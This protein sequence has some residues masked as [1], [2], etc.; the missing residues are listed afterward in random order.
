MPSPPSDYENDIMKFLQTAIEEGDAFLQT[1]EGYD[2][3]PQVI[4]A[5]FNKSTTFG[6]S[7][8][9]S[10]TVNHFAR[11]A[12]DLAAGMTDVRPFWEYRTANHAFDRQISI[13]GRLSEH[14]WLQRQADMRFVDAM[15]YVFAAGTAFPHLTWNPDLQ[16]LEL[17]VEDPRDVIPIRPTSTM[18]LQD[19]M[20]VTIRRE[21]TVNYLRDKYRNAD[22]SKIVAEKDASMTKALANTRYG[23]LLEKLGSPFHN[24]MQQEATHLQVPKIPTCTCYTTYLKDHTLNKGSGPRYMGEWHLGPTKKQGVIRRIFGGETIDEREECPKCARGEY[25]HPLTNWSYAVEPGDPLYP[26]GRMIISTKHGVLHDGPSIYWHGSVIPFPLVKLTLDPFPWSWFGKAAGWDLLP[27]QNSLNKAVQVW[28]DWLAQLAQ[29]AVIADKNS[30]SRAELNKINSRQAGLK[31]R[32]NPLAGKGVQIVPPP[33][34]PNDYWQ[35][36]KF[37]IDSM[38]ELSGVVNVQSLMRLNQ[39]PSSDTIEQVMAAMS[40]SVRLRSRSLEATIREFATLLAYDFTQFYTL[41]MRLTI[42]G[43]Q[44]VTKEDFDFDPG[45]LVPDYVHREDFGPDG[46]PHVKAQLRG[47]RP[48]YVRA[49]EVLRQ[50]EFHVAPGSLLES[51]GITEKMMYLQLFRMGAMDLWTMWDKLGIP[52]IG[53]PPATTIPERLAAQKDMGLEPQV[54]AV[55]RKATGQQTPKMKS[56][57]AIS[58]SG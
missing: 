18:A 49:K 24:W 40:P 13:Y 47:P 3:I 55:G 57:G 11:I 20:G 58:E 33:N 51:S 10:T 41:P 12:L 7:K 14:W 27:L 30:V 4:D 48:R 46:Q 38:N 21:H 17:L 29:P 15:K 8:L 19:C 50:L 2:K 45:T 31:I 28:D 26:N 44:G 37:L 43:S 9:S 34:L 39:M 42:M 35:G 16:D 36:V 56:S 1:Q 22:R 53:E 5:I 32:Q 54:S 6:S 23:R 52:L 25:P